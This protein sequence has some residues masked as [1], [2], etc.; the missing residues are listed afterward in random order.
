MWI[1]FNL[2]MRMRRE[3]KKRVTLRPVLIVSIVFLLRGI[4]LAYL[5]GNLDYIVFLADQ[6]SGKAEKN[7]RGHR[8]NNNFLY[9]NKL[10]LFPPPP[11]T[12]PCSKPSFRRWPPL[13]LTAFS[14][15]SQSLWFLPTSCCFFFSLPAPMEHLLLQPSNQP[16]PRES[17]I[18]CRV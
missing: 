13:P 18:V 11:R 7:W 9:E 10:E 15:S 3:V 2:K 17:R 5:I 1:N 4:S 6:K 14:L 16:P 8:K 12:L